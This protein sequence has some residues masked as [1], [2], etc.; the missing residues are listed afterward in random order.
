MSIGT[1]VK[2]VYHPCPRACEAGGHSRVANVVSQTLGKTFN[3]S[4]PPHLPLGRMK[5]LTEVRQRWAW[6]CRDSRLVYSQ[7]GLS[8][9]P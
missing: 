6:C 8:F 1:S 3:F 4:S 9:R 5:G 2:P 7:L